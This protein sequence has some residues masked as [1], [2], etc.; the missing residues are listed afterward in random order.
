MLL[1][2][3]LKINDFGYTKIDFL[4]FGNPSQ[5]QMDLMNN[6]AP[7]YHLFKRYTKYDLLKNTSQ[8]TVLAI[9]FLIKKSKE[10]VQNKELKQYSNDLRNNFF[11]TITYD[12]SKLGIAFDEKQCL[13]IVKDIEPLILMLKYFYNQIRPSQIACIHDMPLY[14][15][16]NSTTPSFPSER[17]VKAKVLC[18]YLKVYNTDKEAELDYWCEKICKQTLYEGTNTLHENVLSKHLATNLSQDEV[19]FNKFHK[20][21]N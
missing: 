16:Y 17:V 3:K 4:V 18:E 21:N 13:E 15:A 8:D 5:S 6:Q 11:D 12:L 7:F 1:N 10:Y 20:K 2:K 9:N 14:A 19:F